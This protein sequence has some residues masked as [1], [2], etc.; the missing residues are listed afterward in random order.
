M[1]R[2]LLFV[3]GSIVFAITVVGSLMYGYVL[4]DRSYQL[5]A[6]GQFV[7]REDIASTVADAVLVPTHD[8][9]AA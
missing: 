7:R 9:S 6:V 2:S 1:S 3:V 5:G 4:F 8:D